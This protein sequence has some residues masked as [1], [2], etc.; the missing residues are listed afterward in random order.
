[1]NTCEKIYKNI[2]R[3]FILEANSAYSYIPILKIKEKRRYKKRISGL[4]D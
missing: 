3:D 4:G 2:V 1:M